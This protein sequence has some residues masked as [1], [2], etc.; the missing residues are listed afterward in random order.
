MRVIARRLIRPPLRLRIT[1]AA[2][3]SI[4][5]ILV[6][7]SMFVYGRLRG[8]LLEALD[9]GLQVRAEAIASAVGSAAPLGQVLA[10]RPDGRL[11]TATQILTP[12]GRILV[13]TGSEL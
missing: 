9:S 11:A 3:A 4:A 2:T 7:L 12:G 8:Q 10:D 13:S 5:V 6:T 1:M